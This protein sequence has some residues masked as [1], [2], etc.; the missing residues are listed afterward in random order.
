MRYS[1]RFAEINR[2]KGES[3]SSWLRRNREHHIGGWILEKKISGKW[4]PKSDYEKK[5][6]RLGRKD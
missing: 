2:T 6:G 3:R 1:G 4:L 5:T